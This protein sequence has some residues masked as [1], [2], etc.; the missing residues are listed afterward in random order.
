[1][2]LDELKRSTQRRVEAGRKALPEAEL[3]KLLDKRPVRE[4]FVFE[5]AL[6]KTGMSYICEIK[7]ASPSKGII[8]EDFPYKDIAREYAGAGADC[9]SVLTEP[10]YFMG[11]IRYLKEIRELVDTPILRK[12]FTCDTY[13]VTEAAVNGADAILLIA[14]ILSDGELRTLFGLAEELGMSAIF[15]AHDKDEI[16]RCIRAGARIIGVNNRNLKDFSVNVENSGALRQAVPDDII[17]VAESGI[18]TA[19]D[20]RALKRIGVDA[21]LIGEVLMRSPDKGAKLRELD[22]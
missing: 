11:D 12:D 8:A 2:I 1:M 21:C 4:P 16:E 10:E 19:E 14:A 5:K 6:K 7:K 22:E 3:E 9:I 20:V 18:S 15:E 13:M 17:F